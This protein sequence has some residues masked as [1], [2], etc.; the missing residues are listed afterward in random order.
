MADEKKSAERS[1]AGCLAAFACL[2]VVI[3]LEAQTASLAWHGI[4]RHYIPS[5]PLLALWESWAM[6]VAVRVFATRPN[7]PDKVDDRKEREW[8]VPR[9]ALA[10]AWRYVIVWLVIRFAVGAP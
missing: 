4:L 6:Y 9:A 1:V 2:P 5:L 7:V 3:W 10:L 8:Y